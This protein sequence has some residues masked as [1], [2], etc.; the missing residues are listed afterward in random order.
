[1]FI[2]IGLDESEVRRTPWVSYAILGMNVAA[3]LALWAL[4]LP[5]REFGFVPAQPDGLHVLT[6]LFVHAGLLHLAGNMIFFYVT[7]PFVE[8]A[9]GRVLFSI[10]YLASGFVA[11]ATHALNN[12]D[13][14]VPM[15]GASGAIAGIMGAFLVRFARRRIVFFW[16]PFF[17]LPWASR[18][19]SVRAFLYLP[20]WFFGQVFLGMLVPYAAVAFWAHIGGFLFGFGAALFIALFGIERRWIHPKIEARI[21]FEQHPELLKAIEA[22]RRGDVEEAKRAVGRALV[23]NPADLD[24]RRYAYE[25]ALDTGDEAGIALHGTRLLDAYVEQ[26]ETDLARTLVREAIEVG[27]ARMPPRFLLRA[28]DFLARAGDASRALEL[29]ER[30]VAGWPAD[31]GALRAWLRVQE[32]KGRRGDLAGARAAFADAAR[33]PGWGPQWAALFEKNSVEIEKTERGGGYRGTRPAAK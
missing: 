27:P 7:G 30:L 5:I 11:A 14:H 3:F 22:G 1:M 17:P 33:H 16:M 12:P 29:A 6:S 28:S 20:F 4:G 10:L 25:L 31:P 8:D 26:G 9:Y 13:S 15:V 23:A 18:Q 19:I 24:A 32:I 21:A 2:P